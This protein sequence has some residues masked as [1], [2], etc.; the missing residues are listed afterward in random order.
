MPHLSNLAPLPVA[1]PLLGAAFLAAVRKPLPRVWMDSLCIAIASINLTISSA[2]LIHATRASEVYWFGNW[3]PRGSLVLGIAFVIDPIA[4]GLATLTALLFLLCFIFSWRFVDPGGKHFH[5]LMLVFLA[6]M[7]GFVLTGDLFNLFVFFELMSTAA[8]A[9][10]GLKTEEPAPLQG[11]FNFAV[12]NTIAAFMEVTGIALL[13]SITGALNMAQIALSLG[14]RHDPLVLFAFT[15]LTCGFLIKAAIVPFHLWL[16]DAHAVAPTPVC[17]IFS[18]LMVELG[19]YA[20]IRLHSVIFQQ[21]LSF[22]IPALRAIFLT[23]AILTVLLGGIMSYAEHHLKRILAFSTISHMGLMLATYSVQGAAAIAA[24]F[25]YMLAHALIKAALFFIA[26]IMLHRLRSMSEQA[27]FGHGRPLR[28]TAGIWF[29]AGLAL[30]AAPPFS[31]LLGESFAHQAAEEAGVHGLALLFLIGGGLT[32]AAVFRVGFHT[33]LGWGSRPLTDA[34]ARV[35]EMPETKAENQIIFPYHFGPPAFCLLI[36]ALLTF[37]PHLLSWMAAAAAR[38]QFQPGYLHLVY[39][40][41]SIQ[42]A[43][44]QIPSRAEW[45]TA[46]ARGLLTAGLALCLAATSVF[47]LK[48][49][50]YLRVGAWLE[51]PMT[52]LRSLQSG[53]PG[54]YVLWLTA[55]VAAFGSAA[56]ILLRR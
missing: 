8:F 24:V 28:W 43:S 50:R 38:L 29:L 35:D 54:D 12:T 14:P 45:I 4:A 23:L 27:I 49:R 48:L 5:P 1:I 25:T 51:G 3:F 15:L 7:S 30:A 42:P 52:I 46:S 19:L 47:R 55:G 22:H 44:S 13:Y 17:V 34:S 41:I 18:S 32:A 10:C 40:G 6:S 36:A 21:S 9:L 16:P 2:L 33:F 11:A 37:A 31:L 56:V 53:H 20:V 39:T 26:G